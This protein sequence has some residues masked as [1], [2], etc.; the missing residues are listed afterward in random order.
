MPVRRSTDSTYVNREAQMTLPSWRQLQFEWQTRL[1]FDESL[2]EPDD[3]PSYRC[4]DQ[5]NYPDGHPGDRFDGKVIQRRSPCDWLGP[6][7][8]V[9]YGRL[10]SH[11]FTSGGTSI[12]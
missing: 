5:C 2:S 4:C 7:A 8:T 1:P 3:G 6:F 9:C 11:S 12:V 10:N